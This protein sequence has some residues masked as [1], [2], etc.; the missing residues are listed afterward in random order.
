M[1]SSAAMALST[2]QSQVA[3]AIRE[4]SDCPESVKQMF[5][6]ALPNSFGADLHQYQKEAA[7][8][9]RKCLE[10]A[11]T[12][13]GEMQGGTSQ[14]VKEGQT[15]LETLQADL[16]STAAAEEAA[17]SVLDEKVADLEA[18]QEAVKAEKKLCEEAE[19]N[20]G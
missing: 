20:K 15:V 9:L 5:L 8:M 6:A 14:R 10:E 4:L 13:A 11:R 3:K 16:E 18:A 12:T 7:A 19:E 2:A 17:R 1:G